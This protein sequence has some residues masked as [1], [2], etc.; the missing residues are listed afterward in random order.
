MHFSLLVIG[1]DIEEQIGAYDEQLTQPH[2]SVADDEFLTET[3]R[4]HGPKFTLEDVQQEAWRGGAEYARIL[5]DGT[6]KLGSSFNPDGRWDWWVAGGRWSGVLPL[7]EEQIDEKTGTVRDGASSSRL[8]DVLWCETSL[9][10]IHSILRNGEW[11][12]LKRP[13]D[14]EESL[15]EQFR[16][17][18]EGLSGDTPVHIIDC[19][20]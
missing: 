14:G 20:V 8:G 1:D 11:F 19:H 9:S 12:D 13:E 10:L 16:T 18:T 4:I 5:K 6:V 17:L 2:W 7:K 15:M 3:I